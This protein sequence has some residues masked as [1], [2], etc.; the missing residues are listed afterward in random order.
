[1][2]TASDKVTNC[3]YDLHIKMSKDIIDAINK[4]YGNKTGT[5]ADLDEIL[6]IIINSHMA[7]L[8]KCMYLFGKT[9]GGENEKL[10]DKISKNIIA[11]T[12]K[13]AEVDRVNK[14]VH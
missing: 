1:M 2:T 5:M 10:I 11:A 6:T 7:S 9:V 14:E 8:R 3:A 13:Y 4:L 12:Y